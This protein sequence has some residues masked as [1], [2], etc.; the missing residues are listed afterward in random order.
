MLSRVMQIMFA[1]NTKMLVYAASNHLQTL[2]KIILAPQVPT[3]PI[4]H[5]WQISSDRLRETLLKTTLLTTAL[6]EKAT[7]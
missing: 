4:K 1:C 2:K 5:Q 7:H 6:I 3:F